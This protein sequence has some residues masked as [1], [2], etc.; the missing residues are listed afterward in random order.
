MPESNVTPTNGPLLFVSWGMPPSVNGSSVIAENLS[1]QFSP[2]EM[3]LAGQV[4][5]GFGD[6]QRDPALPRVDYVNQEWTWPKRGQKYVRWTR[7]LTLPRIT[8]KLVQIARQEKCGAIVGVF[9]NEFF[10]YAAYRA[11]QRLKLPLYPYFHNTYRENRTGIAR[12]FAD[13]LEPRVFQAAPVV[14]VM[15]EGMQQHYQPIYPQ[16]RFE[17]LVHTFD[18]SIPEFAPPPPP[19]SPLRLAFMGSLNE[20]NV[21]AARRFADVVNSRSDCVLTTYSGIPDWMFAKVGVCGPRIEHT[22]VPYDQVT[23]AL[24]SH[25]ILLFPH[26]LTGG[27]SEIEYE[28]IFPTRTIPSLLSGRPIVAHSPPN[29]FLTRWLRQRDCAEIVEQPDPAALSAA[30]DRLRD[31]P[32]RR[33]TLVRNALAAVRQFQ[34]TV[35]AAEFRRILA[36]TIPTQGAPPPASEARLRPERSRT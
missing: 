6:Y 4:W 22:C 23:T 17:P 36:E 29:S 9:P 13:W 25:D 21:D 26:G 2:S 5:A 15:S 28:T 31:D 27:L 19:H 14:F 7:W 8:R 33:E 30:I 1:R 18:E 3:V 34:G 20:S 16:V 11:A 35:V 32:A 24:R 10:L 12:R